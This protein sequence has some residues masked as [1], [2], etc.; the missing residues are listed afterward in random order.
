MGLNQQF[1]YFEYASDDG[2]P[3]CVKLSTDVQAAGGFGAAVNP[4]EHKV[5]PFGSKNMRYVY[6]KDGSGHRTRLPIAT[7]GNTLYTDGGTFSL[8]GRAYST[9]GAIGEK[10]KLNAIG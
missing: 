1:A 4:L 5:W 10:R 3:Y 6:G 2:T 7:A 9:E 8:Q